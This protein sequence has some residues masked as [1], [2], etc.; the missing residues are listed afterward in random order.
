MPKWAVIT[1]SACGVVALVAAAAF[2]ALRPSGE[3]AAVPTTVPEAQVGGTVVTTTPPVT[4]LPEPTSTTAA[5][6]P[7]PAPAPTPGP[8]VVTVTTT[9]TTLPAPTT[10]TTRAP[11]AS[12][13]A[14][15]T[16]IEAPRIAGAP[17]DVIVRTAAEAQAALGTATIPGWIAGFPFSQN[18]LVLSTVLYERIGCSVVSEFWTRSGPVLRIV[19]GI[20]C[21][22]GTVFGPTT[23]VGADPTTRRV[24]VLALPLSTVAG[25]TSVVRG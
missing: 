5:P 8:T 6:A 4:T 23:E 11:A 25:V 12:G 2:F 22:G 18:A 9:P 13:N 16:V 21:Y 10:T 17:I 14:A 19:Q 24:A 15:V 7:A 3:Q 20:T 1:L